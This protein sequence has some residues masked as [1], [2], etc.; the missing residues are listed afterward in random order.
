MGKLFACIHSAN[1]ITTSILANDVWSRASAERYA[2]SWSPRLELFCASVVHTF[3]RRKEKRVNDDE[4]RE[5]E[6]EKR[7]ND[8]EKREN[9]DEKRVNDDEKRVKYD[10]KRVNDVEKR[11]NESKW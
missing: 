3:A 5:N 8:D 7:V 11:E 4:K 6:D 9:D 10:E 2:E 1:S